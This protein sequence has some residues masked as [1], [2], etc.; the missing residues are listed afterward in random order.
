MQMLNSKWVSKQQHALW[1]CFFFCWMDGISLYAIIP[2]QWGFNN[3]RNQ[4]VFFPCMPFFLNF[5]RLKNYCVM[6]SKQFHD[7][8]HS[9]I[10]ISML[11]L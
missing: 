2:S 3:N 10:A 9:A 4:K 6:C 8:H 1:K 5:S 11:T 7:T